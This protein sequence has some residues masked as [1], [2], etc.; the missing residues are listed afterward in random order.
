MHVSNFS[1][2]DKGMMCLFNFGEVGLLPESFVSYTMS[3][4]APFTVDI[5]WYLAIQ[6]QPGFDEQNPW[7]SGNVS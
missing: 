4:A 6:F 1:I 5:G 2:T 7:I 3:L